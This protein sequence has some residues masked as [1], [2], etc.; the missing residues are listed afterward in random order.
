MPLSSGDNASEGK[1]KGLNTVEGLHNR[2]D[3][4]H[5]RPGLG[6]GSYRRAGE[7]Q[8]DRVRTD[9]E[10]VEPRPQCNT[11]ELGSVPP[12]PQAFVPEGSLLVNHAARGAKQSPPFTPTLLLESY[13]GFNTDA[14]GRAP[15]LQHSVPSAKASAKSSW[16]RYLVVL[17]V[18]AL[19]VVAAGLIWPYGSDGPSSGTKPATLTR[20]SHEAMPFTRAR[21]ESAARFLA[22]QD[23]PHALS[24][25]LFGDKSHL[26]A[27]EE[28]LQWLSSQAQTQMSCPDARIHNMA[29]LA[30]SETELRTQ[31]AALKVPCGVLVWR[32]TDQ[33][34]K[35]MVFKSI[36]DNNP[37]GRETVD[38]RKYVFV[39]MTMQAPKIVTRSLMA[40][41]SPSEL[42]IPKLSN[43]AEE[44]VRSFSLWPD[45]I[46]HVI[47]FHI[48]F[49]EVGPK[50]SQGPG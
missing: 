6:Q 49:V 46:T 43:D 30:E 14:F 11:D 20:V 42:P 26:P 25:H 48:P 24:V 50:K 47:R 31:I 38:P 33:V 45:R 1:T 23:L 7:A 34:Q 40:F 2:R 28:A 41:E 9:D 18:L 35:W 8:Y 29:G 3:V 36:L 32:D 5:G 19:V 27:M 39:F 44:D 15:Q 13:G 12:I 16:S 21:L 4:A 22:Q 17:I 10:L 37:G